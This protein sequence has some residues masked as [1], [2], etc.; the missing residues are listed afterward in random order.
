MALLSG[1]LDEPTVLLSMM[2]FVMDGLTTFHLLHN[3]IPRF[4]RQVR[5][6][7]NHSMQCIRSRGGV[8]D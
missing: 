3:A 6:T 1:N 7:F 5:K 2:P 4:V 8:Q